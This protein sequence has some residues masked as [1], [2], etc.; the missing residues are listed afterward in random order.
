[1]LSILLNSPNQNTDPNVYV[2]YQEAIR[3]II[4]HEVKTSIIDKCQIQNELLTDIFTLNKTNRFCT[5]SRYY[6]H[7]LKKDILS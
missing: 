5:I 6:K 2:L 3:T 1:M 4:K 7:K